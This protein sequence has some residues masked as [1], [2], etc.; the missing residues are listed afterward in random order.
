MKCKTNNGIDVTPWLCSWPDS[1]KQSQG[2]PRRFWKYW[3]EKYA[4]KPML[5]LFSGSCDDGHTRVDIRDTGY[6]N[7]VGDFK[8]LRFEKIYRSAFADPP[9]TPEYADEWGFTY[10]KPSEILKVMKDACLENSIIGVLHLQVLRPIKGLEKIAWH[11]IFCGT[12]KHLRCLSVF[13]VIA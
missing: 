9:Y 12:T 7:V 2:F 10:P 6:N 1:S 13:R 8:K 5:H 3:T 4:E 11:P